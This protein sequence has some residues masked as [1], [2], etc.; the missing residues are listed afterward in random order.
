MKFIDT[1]FLTFKKMSTG[2]R[3]LEDQRETVHKRLKHAEVE[4]R[5]LYY[6]E[7]VIFNNLF[8]QIEYTTRT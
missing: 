7:T 8:R 2:K 3:K 4:G 5:S 6:F 1:F